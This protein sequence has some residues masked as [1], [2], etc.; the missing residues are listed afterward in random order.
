MNITLRAGERLYLNGA[1]IRS[2]R[3][4]TIEL[5][6]DATFLLETHVMQASDATTPLRQVYFV[7]QVML[8][9]P[10]SAKTTSQL[11]RSLIDKSLGAFESEEIKSRLRAVIELINRG[12]YFEAMKT[13]R[14]MYALEQAEMFPERAMAASN[15][16]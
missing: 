14:G 7:I 5:L 2:D 10:A 15:A 16:A 6:N 3:K 12:R 8:M 13:L 9:D 4:A 1:V 11:A